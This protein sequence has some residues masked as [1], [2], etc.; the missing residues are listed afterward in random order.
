[1]DRNGRSFE[2]T[3]LGRWLKPEKVNVPQIETLF[4]ELCKPAVFA[5]LIQGDLLLT[6][7]VANQ[8]HS[9]HG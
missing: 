3:G 1:M 8:L 5:I 9:N 7:N 6:T 4:F 2:K